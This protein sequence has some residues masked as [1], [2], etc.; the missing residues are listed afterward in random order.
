MPFVAPVVQVTL[1]ILVHPFGGECEE[2][3]GWSKVD[4]GACDA[5]QSVQSSCWIGELYDWHTEKCISWCGESLIWNSV[6]GTCALPPTT[7]LNEAKLS[8][9]S[10]CDDWVTPNQVNLTWNFF[11]SLAT[12]DHVKLLSVNETVICV[13][14][15]WVRY[16][17]SIIE[18]QT[19]DSI[20]IQGKTFHKLFA[21]LIDSSVA[22][23]QPDTTSQDS[24]PDSEDSVQIILNQICSKLEGPASIGMMAVSLVFLL[25]MIICYATIT[26]LQNIPGYMTLSKVVALMLAYTSFLLRLAA[27]PSPRGCYLLSVTTHYFFLASY[28]WT[29]LFSVEVLQTISAVYRVN[30]KSTTKFLR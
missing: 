4:S 3:L 27:E 2:W 17:V 8:T 18:D 7:N 30:Q 19:N 15:T 22:I 11:D 10:S 5:F 21:V 25:V 24:R 13:N 26:E 28:F 29:L 14:C 1:R 12:T 6:D 23:C 20:T 16:N 9:N